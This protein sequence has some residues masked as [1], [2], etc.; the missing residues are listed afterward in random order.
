M[1]QSGLQIQVEVVQNYPVI[2][3]VA[4]DP[5]KSQIVKFI[6]DK[7]TVILDFQTAVQSYR[8]NVAQA[9]ETRNILQIAVT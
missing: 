9:S 7:D 2:R 1:F 6:I 4:L 8:F 5:H 3:I